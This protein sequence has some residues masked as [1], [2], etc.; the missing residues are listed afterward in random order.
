MIKSFVIIFKDGEDLSSSLFYTSFDII[1][2]RGWF[3]EV[4][5][6]T[7]SSVFYIHIY[8]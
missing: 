7:G 6:K 5:Q 4:V 8:D 3:Y 2:K 1:M